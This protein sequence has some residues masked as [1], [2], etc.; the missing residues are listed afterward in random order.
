MKMTVLKLLIKDPTHKELDKV[1]TVHI[2]QD[3]PAIPEGFLFNILSEI[4]R[5]ANKALKGK[6]VI[7]SMHVTEEEKK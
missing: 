3:S 2:V 1:L 5:E 6:Y 4:T 7:A